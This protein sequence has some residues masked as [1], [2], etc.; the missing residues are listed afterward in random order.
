MALIN[1]YVITDFSDFSSTLW[2]FIQLIR[3]QGD[4]LSSCV[5]LMDGG[6]LF[7]FASSLLEECSFLD[8]QSA[9]N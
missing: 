7:R 5:H 4:Q 2:T 9:A 1:D 6:A 8:S 3:R